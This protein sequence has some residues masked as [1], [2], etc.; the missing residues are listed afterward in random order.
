[1]ATLI[2]NHNIFDLTRMYVEFNKV[3]LPPDLAAMPIGE[4]NVENVTIMDHLF[5]DCVNFNEPL[6]GWNVEN[7]TSMGGMF[8]NCTSFN[9]PL[10]SWNV[11]K[12]KEMDCM[13][14]D[15]TNFN[16]PLD[17]WNVSKVKDMSSMFENCTSFN[18]PLQGWDVRRVRYNDDMFENCFMSEN[19]NNHPQ[20]LAEEDLSDSDDDEGEYEEDPAETANPLQIHQEAA[21]INYPQ[22]ILL[23]KSKLNS[24]SLGSTVT[25][26]DSGPAP[27]QVAFPTLHE[28]P[29]YIKFKLTGMIDFTTSENPAKK[30]SQLTDLQRI[31]TERLSGADYSY[32]PA[33]LL[34][35]IYYSIEYAS[36]QPLDFQILY[37][38]AYLHDCI[39]AYDT[40]DTMTCLGGGLERLVSSLETACFTHLDKP[41]YKTIID[42]IKA[43]NQQLITAYILEW[44]KDHKTGTEGAHTPEYLSQAT[45]DDSQD[46]FVFSEEEALREDENADNAADESLGK[47]TIP[48]DSRFH[49]K[50]QKKHTKDQLKRI[51]LKRAKRLYRHLISAFPNEK[52]LI[53]QQIR[54]G[55]EGFTD[56]DFERGGR[57]N[58]YLKTKKSRK[59]KRTK[60]SKKSKKSR[61]S[62]GTKKSK[63]S[64]KTKKI[65]HKV[66]VL[67]KKNK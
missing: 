49:N 19:E 53:R 2:E 27:F 24:P 21:K 18:Q 42:L 37:I 9:Q 4:W 7:V 6:D 46:S 41:E 8:F 5:D 36:K 43:N 22:L 45:Q 32:F 3:G 13:F 56:A 34:E 54:Y 66:L 25:E 23:L 14:Q 67:K 47:R 48:E 62:K 58:K 35:A 1:M 61:K 10:N 65:V 44:I 57:K 60:K 39:H 12:V 33:I 30:A 17:A 29:A 51:W 59:S 15:C 31:M 26:E 64:K 40:G 28:F 16:Q 20:F 52:L 38:E 11:S 50:R 63:K 55:V